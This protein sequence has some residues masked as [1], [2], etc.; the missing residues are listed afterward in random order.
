MDIDNFSLGYRRVVVSNVPRMS[1]NQSQ[2][3]LTLNSRNNC[4]NNISLLDSISE[5]EVKF[6]DYPLMLLSMNIYMALISILYHRSFITTL[7]LK[8]GLN[9]FNP[10]LSLF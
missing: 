3:S 10:F 8:A 6:F 9:L 4:S 2:S 1:L 7:S 5:G